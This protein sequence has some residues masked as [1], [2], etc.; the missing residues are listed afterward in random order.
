M[1]IKFNSDDELNLNKTIEIPS[2]I[3]VV[4]VFFFNENNNYYPQVFVRWMSIII[5]NI[6]KTLYYDKIY[7]SEVININKQVH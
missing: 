2:M 3:I 5:M 6:I 7:V 1:K 4:R